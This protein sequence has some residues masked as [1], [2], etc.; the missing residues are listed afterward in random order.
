MLTLSGIHKSFGELHVLKGIDLEVEAGEVISIVGK[1]GAGKSTLLHIAGTLDKPDGGTVSIDGSRVDKLGKTALARFRNRHIGFVFQFHYLLPEFTALENV[2]IP[3][4]IAKRG[5]GELNREAK[6]ILGYMGLQDRLEHK[7]SQLSGGEQQR[8]AIARAL[9]NRPKV[10]YADEPT[11][12]LDSQTS[13]ELHRL[14]LRLRAE[15][16][17]T[18]VLVTHN[19]ELAELSDRT[20]QMADG[21]IVKEVKRA[22]R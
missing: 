11:G 3:G 17:Q 9:I 19:R 10:V 22:R 13:E 16:G 7:P 4:M 8:V 14:I 21:L 15:F 5:S 18:F 20:L 2:C 1:S 6:E 12:N